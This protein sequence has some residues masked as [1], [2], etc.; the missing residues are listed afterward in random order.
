MPELPPKPQGAYRVIHTADWHLGKTLVDQ[1]R[2][3]EHARFL[4]FL[5]EAI[6]AGA[7]DALVIAGDVFDSS[8]PPQSAQAR[9]YGFLSQLYTTT[10][11][12]VVVIAGN[13]DSPAQLEAP[14]QVLQS[15]RVRVVGSATGDPGE[16][17]VALPGLESPRLV[18]AAV[19]FLRDRDVRIGQCGQTAAEIQ[20]DLVAGIRQRYAEVAA[21]ASGAVA[22]GVPILATGHLTVAGSTTS[23]S[24]REI[25]VGGLGAVGADIFGGR[26]AY[27]ALGHLHRPQPAGGRADVRY[28]GSPIALSFGEAGDTKE[29]R[30]LDFGAGDLVTNVG[31]PIPPQRQLVQLRTRRADLEQSLRGFQPAAADL[32]PWVEVVIEDPVA[33]ENSFERV[34][35]LA[36]GAPYAVVSVISLRAAGLRGLG[37]ADRAEDEEDGALESSILENPREV[38]RVR[39]EREEGL[40]DADRE[41]VT[42]AFSELLELHHEGAA[43]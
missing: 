17:L 16:A 26:F 36:E 30:L 41:A 21:A 2:E 28:A 27:V 7:V 24:E 4:T 43:P 3:E 35:G 34:R 38:F 32:T 31:I 13:H 23:D 19:P 10:D 29:V 11:C 39:L 14:R 33:G 12:A 25:H 37:G 18:V 40:D 5:L 20:R 1:S 42:N 6:V 9:Y 22:A 8:N 15:L